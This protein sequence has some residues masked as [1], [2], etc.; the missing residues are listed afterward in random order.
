MLVMGWSAA[1]LGSSPATVRPSSRVI[2]AKVTGDTVHF[3][4]EVTFRPPAHTPVASACKGKVEVSKAAKG[5]HKA[6]HWTGVLAP[7]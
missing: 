6:P 4:V 2:S 7:H 5:H 1:A 3:V